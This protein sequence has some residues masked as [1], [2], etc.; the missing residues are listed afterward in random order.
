M[1]LACEDN[2]VDALL[3]K[4]RE[5]FSHDLYLLHAY[6]LGPDRLVRLS[7]ELQ[8]FGVT[9][10]FY[11]SAT[12]MPTSTAR[13]M[14]AMDS[15]RCVLVLLTTGLVECVKTG[16]HEKNGAQKQFV[17]AALRKSSK[18]IFAARMSHD[19]PPQSEWSGLLG[20]TL[21]NLSPQSLLDLTDDA[22]EAA[23]H[24]VLDRINHVPNSLALRSKL[25]H[26]P[27]TV[28]LV[29]HQS[30][31][32]ELSLQ[33]RSLDIEQSSF[34]IVLEASH[35]ASPRSDS[36]EQA[37]VQEHEQYMCFLRSV[38]VL[39]KCS[40][41][42]IRLL[43]K[44]LTV[45]TF[46]QGETVFRQGDPGEY[47]FFVLQGQ[48]T[49][50]VTDATTGKF[51]DVATLGEGSYFGETALMS[52]RPRTA[53]VTALGPLRVLALDRDIFNRVLT[54]TREQR[55]LRERCDAL[56]RRHAQGLGPREHTE[57]A[58]TLQRA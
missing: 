29:R 8:R 4:E 54:D 27:S 11:D 9:K 43:A 44:N 22:V 34:D 14:K 12:T 2:L 40:E 32:R 55:S 53:T 33:S 18:N 17:Y 5:R 19:C 31:T 3:V 51:K 26:V 6:D 23:A 30:Q 36:P 52:D 42:E 47:F 41:A 15:C 46:S 35:A 24:A 45:Q 13:L 58:N 1:A 10:V 37:P 28:E 25:H 49:V 16:D 39:N 20:Q 56:T 7:A 21:S 57:E 38:P 50:S 48:V